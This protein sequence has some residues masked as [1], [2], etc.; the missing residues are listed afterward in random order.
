MA[1]DETPH[2]DAGNADRD[3]SAQPKIVVEDPEDFAKT[4][5]LRSIFDARDDY[6]DARRSANRLYEDGELSFSSR[7][8]RIFR[9]L[10]DLAMMME[11]LLKSK[12]IGREIW[13]QNSYGVKD[14][15]CADSD[16]ASADE[17]VQ[18][19]KRLAGKGSESAKQLL[20]KY[21][22]KG[23]SRRPALF[24]KRD[25]IIAEMRVF[26]TS[27]GWEVQGLGKLIERTHKLRYQKNNSKREFGT[28]APVQ[29]ISD[30]AFSDLQDFIRQIGLGVQFDSEQQTKI[31][32][33]VLKEVDQWRQKNV[34]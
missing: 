17:A 25:R 20:E 19:T 9:H 18:F 30:A 23:N 29:E 8:R 6:I 3:G 22:D 21:D 16:L 15:F 31:T 26:A 28:T 24:D 5:Q 14:N 10:Q 7:N 13:N 34:K 33:E 4:R 2:P 27:W 11:P 1:A 32:D 12:Q